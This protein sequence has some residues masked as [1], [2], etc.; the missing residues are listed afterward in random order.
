MTEIGYKLLLS[1]RLANIELSHRAPKR[2]APVHRPAEMAPG[3]REHSDG[4]AG[5]RDR[6]Q[7]GDRLKGHPGQGQ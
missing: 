7:R 5:M 3:T 4:K 1:Y 6:V 2:R